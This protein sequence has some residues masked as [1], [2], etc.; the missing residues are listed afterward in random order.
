MNL[1]SR[2]YQGEDDYARMRRFLQRMPD[3]RESGGDC[4]IGDL[5]WWRFTAK[6]PDQMRKVHLWFDGDELAGFV[7]PGP[8][9]AE[10]LVDP[11]NRD[12]ARTMI[13]WAVANGQDAESLTILAND[14]DLERQR[15]L[16]DLGFVRTDDFYTYRKHSLVGEIETPVL[17]PGY[18]FR[19]MCGATPEIVERRVEVHRAA[20]A[21]SKMSVEKHQGVMGSETYRPDLDLVIASPEGI[22]ATCTIVWHDPVNRIGVFEPVGCA[23][24]FRQLGLTKSLMFE[25]MRRL[26]ALGAVNAFVASSHASLPANR[27]YESCGFQLVDHQ[28]SWVKTFS[29]SAT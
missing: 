1:E 4:T 6:I 26:Q 13:E 16:T 20:W 7:W 12:L 11:A 18:A 25:G 5:D 27:L 23:P 10:I 22:F 19:D 15:L 28:H 3:T 17:P 21:P 29:S 8:G 2:P 9:S 24:D 14:Q